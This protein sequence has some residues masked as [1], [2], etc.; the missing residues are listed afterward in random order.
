MRSSEPCRSPEQSCDMP[1]SRLREHSRHLEDVGKEMSH[2]DPLG[3]AQGTTRKRA[4]MEGQP[5]PCAENPQGSW[6]ER[7]RG[8]CAFILNTTRVSLWVCT[9][10]GEANR[11]G[12]ATALGRG[13][14][15]DFSRLELPWN[16]LYILFLALI[17]SYFPTLVLSPPRLSHLCFV[18]SC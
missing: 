18:F 2:R 6:R 12:T 4:D 14:S 11:R 10:W 1:R 9:G 3:T 16:R 8:W 15:H 13:Q 7:G 5:Q 17:P